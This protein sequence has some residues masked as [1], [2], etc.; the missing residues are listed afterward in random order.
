MICEIIS[1][2]SEI[3]NGTTIDTN[4]N[5]IMERLYKLGV[6]VDLTI[7]V[8]DDRD[9]MKK[10]IGS[11]VDRAD[12]IYII[13]GLGPTEDDHTKNIIS[14]LLNLKLILKDDILN[15]LRER[16]MDRGIK[17]PENNI[18]QALIPEES[19]VLNNNYGTAPGVFIKKDNK[20]IFLF[21]GPPR[22]LIPMFE[23][24][25]KY[26]NLNGNNNKILT[27]NT[28]D[29]GESQ[30][31]II[32]KEIDIPKEIE[33]LTYPK[34][35]RV[36][37]Q[38]K[39][40]HD[41]DEDILNYLKSEIKN[42]LSDKVY[43]Y[44]YDSIE[45]ILLDLSLKNN[46]K[47]AFA[48]SCTGGLLA[49][50]FTDIPGASKVLNRSLVTYTNEAKINELNVNEL[51]LKKY[52]AVSKETALE[53]AE[54]VRIKANVDMGISITGV[55]GPGEEEG[56]KQGLIYIG[57]STKDNKFVREHNFNGNRKIIKSLA[58]SQ[59]FIEAIKIIKVD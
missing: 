26:L 29:I 59:G 54:G 56:K 35:R 3:M 53:M 1:T 27:I 50:R 20:K 6:E 13:G 46:Y 45:E 24:S 55:A 47:L 52:G 32:L 8:S 5:Y 31:E 21:P 41:I 14:E 10:A 48:E 44:D 43:G 33:V 18:Q 40:K 12:L 2:G 7:S 15:G 42:K 38:L 57:V 19:T 16:Y 58:A 39:F 9:K 11:S 4:S 25:I 36:D 51:T 22:E 28:L 17:M 30:L 49:S 23:D 34:D 37:I